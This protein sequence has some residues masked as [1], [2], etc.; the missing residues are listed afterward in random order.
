MASLNADICCAVSRWF[1]YHCD[2]EP[3]ETIAELR[4][5]ASRP[6]VKIQSLESIDQLIETLK[7]TR[8]VAIKC[9]GV[10]YCT[11]ES[12][13][14]PEES[15]VMTIQID[16]SSVAKLY[17][18]TGKVPQHISSRSVDTAISTGGKKKNLEDIKNHSNGSS[19]SSIDLTTLK[20]LL[21]QIEKVKD[22]GSLKKY[23]KM[24]RTMGI[25]GGVNG[26][27]KAIE[28]QTK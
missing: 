9:G 10:R 19:S 16:L 21:A 7:T 11:I 17:Q 8:Q 6:I 24:L 5:Q 22:D 23:R 3:L 13:V 12:D 15:P 26:L 27:K 14:K 18:K 1:Y 4:K 25:K 28:Q 20:D 2:G